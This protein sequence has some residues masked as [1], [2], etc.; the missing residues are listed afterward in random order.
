MT[1]CGRTKAH[2][3]IEDQKLPAC[4]GRPADER[5][6]FSGG[7][8]FQRILDN[9]GKSPGKMVFLKRIKSGKVIV[10]MQ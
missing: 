2:S 10:H 3:L 7:S 5:D 6:L 8:M 9:V 1:E 4:I